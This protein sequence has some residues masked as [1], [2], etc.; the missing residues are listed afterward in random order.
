MTI[1]NKRNIMEQIALARLFL[2][3][4]KN[5]SVSIFHFIAFASHFSPF[6]YYGLAV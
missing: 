1:K 2:S 4:N 5:L 6:D 3:F